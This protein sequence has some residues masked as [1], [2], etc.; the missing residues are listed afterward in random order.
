MGN[1]VSKTSK[2]R[3]LALE[4]FMKNKTSFEKGRARPGLE[5]LTGETY[6][7]PFCKRG[8]KKRNVCSIKNWDV[9]EKPF[10][11]TS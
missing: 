6:E 10:F 1:C 4:E 11:K 5:R 8:S 9:V 7:D 3:L 2:D